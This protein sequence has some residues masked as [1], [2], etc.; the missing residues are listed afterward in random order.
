V[1]FA[2]HHFQSEHGLHSIL[3]EW[4]GW[5][6]WH[7]THDKHP[8]PHEHKVGVTES[9]FSMYNSAIGAATLTMPFVVAL[10][11]WWLGGATILGMGGL[12]VL[13]SRMLVR[14]AVAEGVSSYDAAVG[15]VLGP[16]WLRLY[17]ACIILSTI[18]ALIALLVLCGDF[19]QSL[20]AMS[21]VIN[22][23]ST[24]RIV[25]ILCVAVLAALPLA[26]LRSISALRV[27]SYLSVPIVGWIALVL[28]VKACTEPAKDLQ[29]VKT[30]ILDY[31]RAFVIT[32]LAFS[33]QTS[34]LPLYRE[35]S[36]ATEAKAAKYI[37]YNAVL[38]TLTYFAIGF[39]SAG[40]TVHLCS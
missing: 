35:L 37:G 40:L 33:S 2:S 34:V 27:T 29:A 14:V 31:S 17:Q 28:L 13:T 25:S 19:A 23:T 39:V 8:H 20:L 11:G 16:F 7:W 6:H 26:L 9:T 21:S 1:S 38:V 32:A 10:C 36:E 12:S 4:R 22:V 24:T 15:R 3:L 18:G 30:T 5:P